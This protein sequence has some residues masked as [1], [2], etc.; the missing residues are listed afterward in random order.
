MNQ[1]FKTLLTLSLF[2]LGSSAVHA[3]PVDS[4]FTGQGEEACVM[5]HNT[6]SVNAIKG[7]KHWDKSLPNSPAS[8]EA[9]ESCHGPSAEHVKN[10]MEVKNIRF[11]AGSDTPADKQNETCTACHNSDPW[12]A[13]HE[14]FMAMPD[15]TCSNCHKV[16]ETK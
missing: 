14:G 6:D 2:W 7:N 1:L 12:K 10:P 15:Q 16:H 9:C 3:A 5:C 13:T 11:G 8:K 4:A